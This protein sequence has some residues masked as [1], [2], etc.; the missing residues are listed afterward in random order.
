M[1]EVVVEVARVFADLSLTCQ[2]VPPGL[3]APIPHGTRCRGTR[4]TGKPQMGFALRWPVTASTCQGWGISAGGFADLSAQADDPV[5]TTD[6]GHEATSQTHQESQERP[7][8]VG[9]VV[10]R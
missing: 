1:A 8:F 9:S 10:S 5:H 7:S 2:A 6:T 3:L 4:S